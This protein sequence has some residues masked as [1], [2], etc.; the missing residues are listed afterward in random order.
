MTRLLCLLLMLGLASCSP[1]YNAIMRDKV[2]ELLGPGFE[3]YQYFSYPTDNFGIA[4]AYLYE[5]DKDLLRDENFLCDTWECLQ[6]EV[7]SERDKWLSLDEFAAFGDGGGIIELSEQEQQQISLNFVLP[8]IYHVAEV[9]GGYDRKS[10]VNTRLQLGRVYPRK[11]RRQRVLNYISSLPEENLLRKAFNEGNLVLVIAD[12]V[13]EEFTVI[14]SVNESQTPR[15]DAAVEIGTFEKADLGVQVSSEVAGEYTFRV[16]HPVILARLAH[17]QP[18][19]GTLGGVEEWEDWES[20]NIAEP[21]SI[22]SCC[23]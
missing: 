23:R 4:T 3:T 1:D 2:A 10:I 5:G 8:K 11:L 19:A 17:K 21:D 14:I 18:L 7:P 12:V 6:K 13:I 22:S 16:S 20:I 9:G 15:L